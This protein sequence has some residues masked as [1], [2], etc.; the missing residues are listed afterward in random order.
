MGAALDYTVAQLGGP[1]L[2][3]ESNPSISTSPV[4]V[5]PNNADRVGLVVVNLGAG[6]VFMSLGNTPSVSVGIFLGANG[7]STSLTVRDDFTL[8]SRQW[9]AICPA[10]GPSVLEVIEYIRFTK[11]T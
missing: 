5:V 8:P 7:G 11:K 6:N 1:V 4:Q 3:Q 9:T 2:E 10:G